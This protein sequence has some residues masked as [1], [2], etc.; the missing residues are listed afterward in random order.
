MT[1]TFIILL[2]AEVKVMIL[3]KVE[4]IMIQFPKRS[5]F[6]AK[7]LCYTCAHDMRISIDCR[8]LFE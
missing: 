1:F 5:L 3:M 4:F 2:S 6:I 8:K 7:P